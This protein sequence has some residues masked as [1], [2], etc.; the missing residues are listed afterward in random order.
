MKAGQQMNEGL[1]SGVRVVSFTHFFVGAGAAQ[2]LADLGAEVIKVEPVGRGAWERSWSPGGTMFGDTSLLLMMGSRNTKSIAVDLKSDEGRAVALDLVKS[3]DIVIQNYRPGILAKFGLDYASVSHLNPALV[4]GSASGYGLNSPFADLPGQDYLLQAEAGMLWMSQ[5]AG[6]I[7]H[8][9]APIVDMHTATLLAFGVTAALVRSRQTGI[10]EHVEV[11]MLR[12]A[13]ELQ[14]EPLS[15]YLNGGRYEHRSVPLTASYTVAPGGV[16]PT[17]DGHIALSQSPLADVLAAME[18]EI[19][20]SD[21]G[22][23]ADEFGDAFDAREQIYSRIAPH[24]LGRTSEEW[25][26]MLRAK[27]IWCAQVTSYEHIAEHPP[28]SAL[29]PFITVDVE[30]GSGVRLVG[31]PISYG[32][33]TP[34]PES[35]APALGEHTSQILAGIGYSADRIEQLYKSG[36]VA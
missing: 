12:A 1:L 8:Y 20:L 22:D 9:G 19:D 28:V 25:I 17:S 24:F 14:A 23:L 31:H 7:A 10:G 4:Y 5:R 6:S 27:R 32:G 34:A 13:L 30:G 29:D 3:A 11:E 36:A 26:G 16:Y 15:V 33:R 35:V 2:Y 21:L 18:I